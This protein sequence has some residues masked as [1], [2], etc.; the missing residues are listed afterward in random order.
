MSIRPKFKRA[1]DTVQTNPP[2]DKPNPQAPL[3]PAFRK[4]SHVLVQSIGEEMVL[5]NL[6]SEMYFSLDSMGARFWSVLV[7]SSS[8]E[9]AEATLLEE[10]D[11]EP[12]RLRKDL[13]A[14]L[15]S[16]AENRLI[17]STAP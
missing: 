7:E 14:I 13:R 17:E 10:F 1:S 2:A 15:A 5:L 9:E 16:M 4:P 3:K 8:L 6:D 12:D 11:V